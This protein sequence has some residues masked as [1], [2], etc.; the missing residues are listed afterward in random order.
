M[1]LSHR[2]DFYKGTLVSNSMHGE[3]LTLPTL[4]GD[5]NV[6]IRG[7]TILPLQGNLHVSDIK[8]QE[9]FSSFVKN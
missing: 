2:Y 4:L 9:S 7:G 5:M 8:L 1:N 3:N 6:H